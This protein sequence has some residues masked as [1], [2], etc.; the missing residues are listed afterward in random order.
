ML[1]SL[2]GTSDF[3]IGEGELSHLL[4]EAAGLD[5]AESVGLLLSGDDKLPMRCAVARLTAERGVMRTDVG[6]IDT[7]DTTILISGQILLAQERLD[8]LL[9]AKPK[10]MS[11]LT[12]RSPVRVVGSFADPAVK[13]EGRSIGLRLLAAAALSAVTPLAGMLAL[14]DLGDPQRAACKDALSNTAAAAAGRGAQRRAPR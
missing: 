9:T 6:L 7:P 1:A 10:D 12:L 14:I 2:H 11:P 8:L 4:V 13:L 5:V 3:W